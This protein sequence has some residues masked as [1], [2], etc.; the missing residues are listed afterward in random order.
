MRTRMSLAILSFAAVFLSGCGDSIKKQIGLGK[1]SPDEFR[2]VTRAPLSLPPDYNLVPPRP[3]AVRPQEGAVRDRARRATFSLGGTGDEG[4][5][6]TTDFQTVDRGAGEIALLKQAGA[7]AAPD[8][9]RQL[10]DM[11]TRNLNKV[12]GDLVD[13]LVFWKDAPPPGTVVD[14]AA[15][16]LRLQENAALGTPGAG[17]TPTITRNSEAPLGDILDIF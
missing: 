7:G 4:Q 1:R 5:S 15:E 11:E 2:V 13:G 16:V 17:E 9:I 8:D 6:K 14:P 12:S 3:G 10:V